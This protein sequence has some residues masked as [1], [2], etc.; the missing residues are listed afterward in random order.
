MSREDELQ[1]SINKGLD[2][3][4][5]RLARLGS[6][7]KKTGEQISSAE[8]VPPSPK[9]EGLGPALVS[10]AAP[11]TDI[12]ATKAERERCARIAEEYSVRVEN[13]AMKLA[14]EGIAAAIRSGK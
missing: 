7:I 5:E 2:E 3:I 9:A 1:E 14:A 13:F 11:F 4:S 8:G 12:A 10:G 6:D